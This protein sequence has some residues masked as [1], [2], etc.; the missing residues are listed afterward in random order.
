MA[1][2]KRGAE[3]RGISQMTGGTTSPARLSGTAIKTVNGKKSPY[4]DAILCHGDVLNAMI[5]TELC[6]V[7]PNEQ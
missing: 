5:L 4:V 6:N 1:L 7:K 3:K 2:V